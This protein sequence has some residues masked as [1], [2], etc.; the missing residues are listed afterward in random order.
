M[1]KLIKEIYGIAC[2]ALL[3]AIPL[4]VVFAVCLPLTLRTGLLCLCVSGVLAVVSYGVCMR[5]L[6]FCIKEGLVQFDE[7]DEAYMDKDGEKIRLHVKRSYLF[8]IIGDD[9]EA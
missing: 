7:N 3:Y 9:T 1:L 6:K 4:G 8:S 2:L 5:L